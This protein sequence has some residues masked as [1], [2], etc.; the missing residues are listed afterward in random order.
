MEKES[1]PGVG[2]RLGVKGGG[3]CGLSYDLTFT[4]EEKGDTII[5]NEHFKVFIDTKSMIY[6]N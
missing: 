5:E 6:K 4:P 2:L 1:K 3:C